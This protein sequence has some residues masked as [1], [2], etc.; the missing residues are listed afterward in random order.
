MDEPAAYHAEGIL[1]F[2]P[3]P[4]WY[5]IGVSQSSVFIHGSSSLV[6]VAAEYWEHAQ[7]PS[8]GPIWKS[9]TGELRHNSWGRPAMVASFAVQSFRAT[10]SVDGGLQAAWKLR[11][12]RAVT[13][14]LLIAVA[15][16]R[17]S[18]GRSS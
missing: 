16:I 8:G 11:I 5:Y 1:H 6:M 18:A 14:I 15:T 9:A 12:K 10:V 4:C 7:A 13:A 17:M 2:A 3:R